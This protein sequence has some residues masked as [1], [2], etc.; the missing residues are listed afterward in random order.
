MHIN[1][2]RVGLVHEEKEKVYNVAAMVDN[3]RLINVYHKI[4]LPNYGVLDG[5]RYFDPRVC[6]F[7]ES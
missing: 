4:F 1:F 2:L 3:G 7:Y 5:R 6:K